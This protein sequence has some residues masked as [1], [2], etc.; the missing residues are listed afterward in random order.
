MFTPT[1]LYYDPDHFNP[2]SPPLTTSRAAIP[3][4]EGTG[5]EAWHNAKDARL[6]SLSQHLIKMGALLVFAPKGR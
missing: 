6:N 1:A 3:G 5:K 4:N 2:P